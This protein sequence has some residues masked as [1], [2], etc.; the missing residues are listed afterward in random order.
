MPDATELGED[1]LVELSLLRDLE[2]DELIRN[3]FLSED[4]QMTNPLDKVLV[5]KYGEV[6]LSITTKPLYPAASVTWKLQ[7]YKLSRESVIELRAKL[8]QI[9]EAAT[10]TNNISS[11]NDREECEDGF[12]EPTMTVFKLAKE[13]R[14]YLKLWR[15]K[16]SKKPTRR[17]K[18]NPLPFE[19]KPA[20]STMTASETAY[21]FLRQ[22]P[23]EICSQIPSSYRVLYVEEV[24]RS[25]LAGKFFKKQMEIKE[26]LS[27]YST[28]TLHGCV[29]AS[30]HHIKR[31]EVYID[32]L[33]KPTM[34]FHGTQRQLVPS[35]VRYGF[36]KPGQRNPGTNQEHGIRC[37]STYGRGIYSS[38]SADFALSYTGNACQATKPN[39]YF[40]IKL[41]VCATIM[42]R[43][44]D[45]YREDNWRDQGRAYPGADSHISNRGLEYIV[46]NSAQIL[47]IYVI[48][49]DWGR[50]NYEHFYKLPSN[51]TGFVPT[52][53]TRHPKL[54]EGVRWPGDVQREKASVFARA[55]K[56]FPYGYGPST[57]SKFVVEE[58]GEVDEDEE[59][60]GD[61]Q[62]LRGEEIKDKTN[63]NFWSWVKVGEEIDAAE[64]GGGLNEYERDRRWYSS[65][66]SGEMPNWD[67]IPNPGE[68]DD[69]VDLENEDDLG[70][71]RLM[72]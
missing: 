19:E 2:V 59:E 56:W 45:V 30:L 7:S 20:N 8:S 55:T 38:P 21:Y 16:L 71:G 36:L 47:P 10:V 54:L 12:F 24:I 41:F 53:K 35:I 5:L 25:D 13:T 39:E 27:E 34:T 57:G 23:Q 17:R 9:V 11:W 46:F 22:T 29:P 65:K 28:I 49:I 66:A 61:Y 37:G 63:L 15:E 6:D 67:E 14:T 4:E 33:V 51:P 50:D 43:T 72:I 32:H 3:G 64:R 1:D 70:I 48:H 31:K 58:V 26:R 42:G 69:A 52:E 62:A 68:E 60:Y 44:A 18:S 40:G